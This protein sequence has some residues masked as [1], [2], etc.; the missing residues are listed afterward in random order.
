MKYIYII[1][2]AF[3]D[4]FVSSCLKDTPAVDFTTVGTII[5]ILP[6]N[7]GG[8]ENFDAAPLEF[9]PSDEIDSADIDLNIASPKPL[10]KS[11]TDY[12]WCG[13]CTSD[14]L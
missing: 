10:N 6:V 8:L 14:C 5:E 12:T 1:P 11:L 7:G 13:R 2:S 4:P 3:C 9:D